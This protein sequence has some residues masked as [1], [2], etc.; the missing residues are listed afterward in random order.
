MFLLSKAPSE[1]P[2]GEEFDVVV[3]LINPLPTELTFAKFIIEGA[4][5]GN[6]HK[7]AVTGKVA[8][9]K[10]ARVVVRMTAARSGQRTLSAKFYSKELNDVDGYININVIEQA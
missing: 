5:L 3:S 8:P 10:E 9:G 7:V 6:P 2:L 1:M 4:G